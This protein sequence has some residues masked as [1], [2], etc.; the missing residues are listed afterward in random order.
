MFRWFREFRNPK[1]KCERVGH[2]LAV[3]WRS[4]LVHPHRSTR[5][6]S[7]ADRVTEERVTCLCCKEPQS[8]FVVV[9]RSSIQGLN[10][11]QSTFTAMDNGGDWEER[12]IY[13]DRTETHPKYDYD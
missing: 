2:R 12:G 8:E 6:R 9:K 3:Q 7:V 5:W 11:P 4:G 13:R 10:A 1:L